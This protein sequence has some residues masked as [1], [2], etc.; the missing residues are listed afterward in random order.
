MKKLRRETEKAEAILR[1]PHPALTGVHQRDCEL[2]GFRIGRTLH[3]AL[4]P[5]RLKVYRRSGYW[6]ITWD[7]FHFWAAERSLSKSREVFGE[8]ATHYYV[9][10][11]DRRERKATAEWFQTQRRLQEKFPLRVRVVDVH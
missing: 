4:E 8:V 9:E 10:A 5:I 1:Y 11:S 6:C 2:L 7:D 3:L